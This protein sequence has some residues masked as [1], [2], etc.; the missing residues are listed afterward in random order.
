MRRFTVALAALALAATSVQAQAPANTQSPGAN[1]IARAMRASVA[2]IALNEA[3]RTSLASLR[4]KYVPRFKAITDSTQP[5][6]DRLQTAQQSHDSAAI[7]AARKELQTQRQQGFAV[8]R[9]ALVDVRSSLAEPHRRR[10]DQNLQ[11]IRILL[12]PALNGP[13]VT[14]R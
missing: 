4:T 9:T 2:G 14:D 3:E 7:R 13:V 1:R 12:Q 8:I 11:V 10:F 5:F 6:A